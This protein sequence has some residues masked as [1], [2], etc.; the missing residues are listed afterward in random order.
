MNVFLHRAGTKHNY[1]YKHIRWKHQTIYNLLT[2][3]IICMKRGLYSILETN[4]A[5]NYNITML[6]SQW[7][8]NVVSANNKSCIWKCTCLMLVS[9]AVQW[10]PSHSL[11]VETPAPSEP[12]CEVW[13]Q[14]SP[15][16]VPPKSTQSEKTYIDWKKNQVTTYC[17][18]PY[19]VTW[20]FYDHIDMYN[21]SR[22]PRS[23]V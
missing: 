9:W 23:T 6:V 20:F 3:S 18:Y 14:I 2:L 13:S 19:L 10:T 22:S 1:T 21:K 8:F 17:K 11:P 15:R 7:H 4:V 16:S 12:H 5:T